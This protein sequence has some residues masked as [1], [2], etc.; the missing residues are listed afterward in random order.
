MTARAHRGGEHAVDGRGGIA[1]AGH[2]QVAE[3]AAQVLR[4]GGNAVDAAVAGMFASWACE[5]LLTGPCG[6]GYLLVAGGDVEPT[7]LD[8]FCAA[9]GLGGEPATAPLVA[10]D[11][12]FGDTR[13]VFYVGAASVA[14]F[15]MTA[16]MEDAVHRWGSQPLADLAEPGAVL[17]H[18]GI[19]LNDVQAYVGEILEP[20]LG[21]TPGVRALWM[22]EG[23][24]LRAGERFLAPGLDETIR[25]IGREG[26]AP[27][28]T[29]DLAAACVEL[30]G[31][32]GGALTARDLAE[33]HP[34][35]SS[36]L[37]IAYR[38]R[39]VLT[40][41]PSSAGGSLLA[42]A[43]HALARTGG[44]PDAA[45]LLRAMDSAQA[46]RT[47]A[48]AQ[49]LVTD[50]F[51]HALLAAAQDGREAVD[52]LLARQPG[53]TTHLSVLDKDGLACAVTCSNGECSGLVV[54]E[55]GLHLNNVMGEEDLNP[56][57]FG[58]FPPGRRMPSMMCPTAVLG[59]G[60]ELELAL[61]SAGSNRIRSA[62]LRTI[63]GFVDEGLPLRDAVDAAR[64]HR[65]GDTVFVEPGVP[66]AG[67]F[68]EARAG[69][70]GI[71]DQLVEFGERNL[72]FGGV[73]AVG[74]DRH[75][76]KHVAAGDP[77]RGGAVAAA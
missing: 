61:G 46:V 50:G 69:D 76:G 71:P 26:A 39:V 17:A 29:G 54:P 25:R 73:Q 55:T 4:D 57:G 16:M 7:V 3:V 38:D 72:F 66:T 34:T 59:P 33:H 15:G 9:P 11:C 44:I 48:F 67:L 24:L 21:M 70:Q 12:D 53:S 28:A 77:R 41:P 6:G 51:A 36:P 62:L 40:T 32:Q 14:S 35:A 2:P 37:A 13:Q 64:L 31:Q 30:V 45:E 52:A 5:P 65:E 63:V 47:P 19:A 60:G 56:L 58:H 68:D 8:G 22:P 49:H 43:L 74:L 20:I 42:V 10:A 23:R 75:T 1:A 27:L 18:R